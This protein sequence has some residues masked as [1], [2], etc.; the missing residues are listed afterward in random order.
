MQHH[1]RLSAALVKMSEWGFIAL[2]HSEIN[3]QPEPPTEI[4]IFNN[5]FAT[6]VGIPD[7]I[8][9]FSL[10]VPIKMPSVF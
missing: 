6:I 3:E 1:P 9:L 8:S 4:N 7:F 5:T 2:S 10:P